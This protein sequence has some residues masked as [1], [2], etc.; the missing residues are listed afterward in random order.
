MELRLND[1]LSRKTLLDLLVQL[2]RES[3][4]PPDGP[5]PSRGAFS[6]FKELAEASTFN[7]RSHFTGE[8]ENAS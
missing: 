6:L 5:G 3:R 7:P 8:T 2:A 4:P 1:S